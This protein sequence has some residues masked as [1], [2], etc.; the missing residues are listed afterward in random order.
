MRKIRMLTILAVALVLLTACVPTNPIQGELKSAGFFSGLWH[1]WIAPF[2]LLLSFLN[3]KY[4]IYQ[5]INSGF[6][7]DLGF[8]IAIISGFGTVSLFRKK[9]K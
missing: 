1:G 6:T 3:D 9:N 7:Y 2:S 5:T 4:S 8:Y